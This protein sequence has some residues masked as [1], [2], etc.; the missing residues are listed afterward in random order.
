MMQGREADGKMKFIKVICKDCKAENIIFSGAT[1][2]VRCPECNEMQVIPGGGKCKIIN[3]TSQ[4]E[5]R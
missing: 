3:C 1:T 4:E 5:L 2:R